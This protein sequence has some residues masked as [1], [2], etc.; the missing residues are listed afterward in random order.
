MWPPGQRGVVEN[1]QHRGNMQGNWSSHSK[2]IEEQCNT[3]AYVKPFLGK[4]W[5][6]WKI[7]MGFWQRTSASW[8]L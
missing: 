5:L 6:F 7:R 8:F 4:S 1:C 3:R 2:S